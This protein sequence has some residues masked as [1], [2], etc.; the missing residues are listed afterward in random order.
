[1]NERMFGEWEDPSLELE[2]EYDEEPGSELQLLFD[3]D[4]HC[5]EVRLGADFKIEL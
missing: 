2:R 5:R 3:G 4:G 1:M